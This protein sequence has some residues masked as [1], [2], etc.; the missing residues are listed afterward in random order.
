MLDIES[1]F[2]IRK[3]FVVLITASIALIIVYRL[4]WTEK[5]NQQEERYKTLLVHSVYL[6]QNFVL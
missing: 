2:I 5:S 6:V 1:Y 3:A 4:Q